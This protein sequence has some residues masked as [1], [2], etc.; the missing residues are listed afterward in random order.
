MADPT[1]EAVRIFGGRLRDRRR[2]LALSQ[3]DVAHDSSVD[4]AN[5][6]KLERGIGNPTLSTILRLSVTLGVAPE[7]LL[8]GLVD[9]G[10]L[11]EGT[12]L[13]TATEYLRE[14]ARRRGS[15]S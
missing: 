2:E 11:P 12:R 3:Y 15:G 8:D 1:S 14:A 7:S 6:G 10:L 4:L 13:F 9:R 5:Y